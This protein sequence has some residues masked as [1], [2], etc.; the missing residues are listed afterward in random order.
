MAAV[1]DSGRLGII[2]PCTLPKRPM[3]RLARLALPCLLALAAPAA[4]AP[5]FDGTVFI[6]PDVITADDPT[7]LVAMVDSGQGARQMFDRRLN[8]FASYNAYLFV[9]QYSDAAPV[10]IQVNPEYGDVDAAREVAVMYAPIIGRLPGKRRL[11]TVLGCGGNGITFSML[12]A[13]LIRALVLGEQDRDAE[14]F[15]PR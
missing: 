2:G 4:A 1:A 10:E 9:A 6:D 3:T 11:Y 14:L 12:A 8:A 15:S 13:Q 5:P 7:T